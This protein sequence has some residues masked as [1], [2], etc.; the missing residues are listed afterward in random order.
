MVD[1][2]I[3]SLGHM[4]QRTRLLLTIASILLVAILIW[5]GPSF[6]RLY[7]DWPMIS[8]CGHDSRVCP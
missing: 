7:Q 6:Y 2:G 1:V 8:A 4:K 5:R 3:C